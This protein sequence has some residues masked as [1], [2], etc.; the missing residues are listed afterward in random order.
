MSKQLTFDELEIKQSFREI[1]GPYELPEGWR[2]IRLGDVVISTQ[3]GISK[4]MNTESKGVPIIRMNN[5]TNDGRLDLSD[6][7][8]VAIDEKTSKKYFLE[9]GDLLFNRTN[10]REL[11]GK[12]TVFDREEKYVFASYIIRVKLN[13]DIV[14]PKFVSYFLNSKE[15]KDI[16][17]NIA[18]PAIQ[19]ANINAEEFCSIKI[20]I[21][22]KNN[23]PNLEEQKRIVA[24]IEELFSKIDRIRELRRQAKEEA[25]NLLKAAL[26]HVFSRADERGWKW[27]KLKD[28]VEVNKFSVN[29]QKDFPEKKFVYIDISGVEKGTG[30][31]KEVKILLGKEAPSRARR[32]V[33][34]NDILMST[35]RPVDIRISLT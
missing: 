11:V 10:S 34:V 15:G 6:I 24:K 3:Y 30:S 32:L 5:I 16:L 2:W 18:R 35:V 7:K 28:I 21:P 8:Y 4:S 14:C 31:I 12:T 19:M 29:P 20:P 22:F 33:H 1:K 26:H 23:K 25:E 17:F 9:K 13:Q 27:V